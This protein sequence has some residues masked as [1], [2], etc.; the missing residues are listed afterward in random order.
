MAGRRS[1]PTPVVTREQIVAAADVLARREGIDNVTVRRISAALSV[2]APALYWHLQNKG[3]LM[4]QLVDRI[5]ARVAH[6]PADTGPW[7]DR[8]LGF[9]SSIR[10]VF[11]EYPGIST[12]LMT[13]DPTEATLANCVYVVQVLMDAGFEETAAVL[14]FNSLSTLSIGHLMMIDAARHQQRRSAADT[15]YA[16]NA[17][18]LAELLDARPELS[19]FRQALVELDDE[20]SRAQFLSGVE[21][22][23]RGAATSAGVAAPRDETAG[24]PE[25][26]ASP[27]RRSV[28][29][30]RR[31]A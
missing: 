5:A 15:A 31:T 22:L 2:T 3:E 16:P 9:Y 8:L 27:R 18:R 30:A 13:T 7:L 6:P 25:V 26:T 10:D 20:A 21:L 28:R 11:G 19:A 1:A 23:I 12:A 17:A 14:L 4:S 24:G 29:S